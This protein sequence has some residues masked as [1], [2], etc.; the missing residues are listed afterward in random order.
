M[1]DGG[2][3]TAYYFIKPLGSG[4]TEPLHL[5]FSYHLEPLYT[6]PR[7]DPGCINSISPALLRP[8]RLRFSAKQKR[9]AG[10]QRRRFSRPQRLGQPKLAAVVDVE[11]RLSARWR[12]LPRR[13]CSVRHYVERRH[14]SDPDSYRL[15]C[16]VSYQVP[17]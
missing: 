4:Q 13:H 11:I 1:T 8:Y 7:L 5:D 9:H 2:V 12:A 15:S 6:Q 3:H 10:G 14:D 16:S 17:P